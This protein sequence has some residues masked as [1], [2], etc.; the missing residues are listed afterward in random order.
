MSQLADEFHCDIVGGDLSASPDKLVIDVSVHGSCEKPLTRK[1]TRAGDL[2]LSSGPLGLSQ[3]G[4]LAL[5]KNKSGYDEACKRHLRPSPRLELI[6]SLVAK[7]ERIHSLMDCS[8]GLI[9]DALQLCPS[10]NGLHIF[11]DSLPL[12]EETTRLALDLKIPAQDFVLWGG[13]DYE[14]LMAISPEDYDQFPN[15][16]LIGR[17]TEAPG[18]FLISTD[19]KDEIKEFKGW[20]HF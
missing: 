2:L 20:K 1:G 14:L 16:T 8:D 6:S 4:L 7:Y 11:A 10:G 5:Q 13:E 18:V 9:N 17:F 12:H 3:T 15:W 19:G